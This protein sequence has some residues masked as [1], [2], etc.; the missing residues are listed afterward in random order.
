LPP[1]LLPSLHPYSPCHLTVC[2]LLCTHSLA[3][4]GEWFQPDPPPS[5][6]ACWVAR[7]SSGLPGEF[8]ATR[9]GLHTRCRYSLDCLHLSLP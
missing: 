4:S 6:E 1:R 7:A 5:R 3:C 8:T 2:R 9:A